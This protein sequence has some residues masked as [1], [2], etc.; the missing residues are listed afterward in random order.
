MKRDIHSPAGKKEFLK[1]Y[2]SSI[3]KE[4]VSKV[5]QMPDEWDG[6]ELRWLATDTFRGNEI[7]RTHWDPTHRTVRRRRLRAYNNERI[8]RNL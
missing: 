2:F 3:C 5:E 7:E 1:E 8:V 4:M 6:F